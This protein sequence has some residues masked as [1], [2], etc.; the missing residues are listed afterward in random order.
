[1]RVCCLTSLD[2]LVAYAEDWDRLAGG[3]PFRGWT[4]LSQW[5]RHYGPSNNAEAART[6]LATLCVFDDDGALVGVAPWYLDCSAMRGRVLRPLGSG[7]V[8]SDYLGLLCHPDRQEAVLKSL[9][10]HLVRSAGNGGDDALR[11]DLIE[12]DGIDA[13]DEMMSAFIDRLA[14]C[15]CSVHRRAGANCWRMELPA[16]W[17]SFVASFGK[18]LR[19]E[20]R[21]L[22]RHLI[23]TNRVV[24][25][26]VTRSDELPWAMDVLVE[27]HQ[28][29]HKTLG[30][31]GCFASARFLGFYRSVVPELLCQGRL[32]FFWLEIDGKPAAAEYQM[33]DNGVVYA[34]QSGVDPEALDFAPGKVIHL[35]ILRQAIAGGYRAF[36]FLRGDEPY[37]ARF[38]A[39]PRPSVEFR[40]APHR[41]VALLR[42]N[43]WLAKSNVKE[44]V[45]RRV[46]GQESG[47]RGQGVEAR[48]QGSEDRES[49]IGD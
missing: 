32:Q 16:N 2:K 33:I 21:R 1:M 49:G 8:C 34:Y 23:Q 48:G 20:I 39:R 40:V 15:G 7:E 31:A 27:L 19:R 22:E 47:V 46:R 38:G 3:L 43:L 36:D 18:N 5:W 42:H 45:K 14:G 30:E 17:E 29:R 41:P 35:M 37:K 12:L 11:W 25:H 13:E 6:H 4:W 24:L 26:E 10:D 9:A 28:R 44:W